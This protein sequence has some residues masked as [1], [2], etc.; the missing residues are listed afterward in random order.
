MYL[1]PVPAEAD[2]LQTVLASVPVDNSD[3][4][5][6]CINAHT[7]Y[8]THDPDQQRHA[9]GGRIYLEGDHTSTRMKTNKNT[10]RQVM[11]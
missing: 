2:R 5:P 8:I 9:C 1:S 3:P 4:L 6:V 10:S 7:D 11:G